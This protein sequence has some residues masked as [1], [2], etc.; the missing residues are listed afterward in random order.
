VLPE[1][2]PVPIPVEEKVRC[3]CLRVSTR[4]Q[5]RSCNHGQIN[6]AGGKIVNIAS[7][8]ATGNAGKNLA[9]QGIAER[10]LLLLLSYY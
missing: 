1:S 10:C 9:Y 4:K 5:W 3:W 2:L 6:G 8:D 7:N